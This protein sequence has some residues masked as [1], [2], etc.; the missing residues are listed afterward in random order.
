MKILFVSPTAEAGTPQYAHN[1]MNALAERG[2]EVALLTGLGYELADFPRSYDLL[3][4]IDRYRPHPRR[5]WAFA[6]YLRRLRPEIIHYQG[7]Q[8][9]A[10]YLIT[11]LALRLASKARFVY[12]PQD[13]LPVR[14]SSHHI[15]A[16]R[17]FYGRMGHVFLNAEQNLTVATQLFRVERTRV[18]VLPMPDLLAFMRDVGHRRV[19]PCVPRDRKLILF[20][21]QIQERKGIDV[22]LDAF[23]AVLQSVPDAQLAIV[24]KPYMDPEPLFDQ[25][26]RLGLQER[27]TVHPAYATFAE[28][29]G[30]FE[31]AHVVALPYRS[32]WNSGVLASA[33]GYGKPV[34]ATRVGGFDEVVHD[35]RNGLLVQPEDPV[36]LSEALTRLL[37]DN[38]LYR[39]ACVGAAETAAQSSWGR[40]AELTED[41]YRAVLTDDR[42]TTRPNAAA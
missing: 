41:R 33:F 35:E 10:T 17:L 37:T 21:G 38:D 29:A 25:I 7:A 31:R 11:W 3:E 32:G 34:V 18:S 42:S 39:R 12:T 16:L 6:Q 40:V 36:G 30:Y 5:L 22:L 9:P 28:M 14:E 13:I 20:F 2:H 1:L 15:H 4:V 19:E 27:A 26:E 24:G 8:R 23:P